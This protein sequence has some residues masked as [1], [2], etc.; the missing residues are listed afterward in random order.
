MAHHIPLGNRP[1][2]TL[3]GFKQACLAGPFIYELGNTQALLGRHYT[4]GSSGFGW[5]HNRYFGGWSLKC[6]W[7]PHGHGVPLLEKYILFAP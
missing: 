5:H 2:A 7:P 3:N 6:L 4:Q 1:P